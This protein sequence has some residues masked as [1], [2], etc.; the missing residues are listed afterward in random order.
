[1]NL[2][3]DTESQVVT[4]LYTMESIVTVVYKKPR[5]VGTIEHGH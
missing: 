1:M 4:E 2:R 5:E 3:S